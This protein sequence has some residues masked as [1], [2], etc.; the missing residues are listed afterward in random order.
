[1][2][3]SSLSSLLCWWGNLDT[4]H[5]RTNRQG[6]CQG[7]LQSRAEFSSANRPKSASAS[8]LLKGGIASCVKPHW[9]AL[10]VWHL[11]HFP[12]ARPAQP[13]LG[14]AHLQCIPPS[15]TWPMSYPRR[16]PHQKGSAG[17]RCPQGPWCHLRSLRPL[18]HSD[19]LG[20][21]PLQSI[22][23]PKSLLHHLL[24]GS[25]GCGPLVLS[26]CLCSQTSYIQTKTNVCLH[27]LI[28][29]SW[30]MIIDNWY[31]KNLAE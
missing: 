2:G 6:V 26:M 8:I 15:L 31:Q 22:S 7:P 28:P 17:A 12:A 29:M 25:V 24:Q 9:Q 20:H 5:S 27:L 19:L 23:H 16:S 30:F 3:I 4:V 10:L 18:A 1:M 14:H 13:T 21:Q 11:L